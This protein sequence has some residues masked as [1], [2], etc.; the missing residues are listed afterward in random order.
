MLQLLFER[1]TLFPKYEVDFFV[2]VYIISKSKYIAYIFDHV[3]L[4]DNKIIDTFIE[5]NVQYTHSHGSLFSN[6]SLYHTIISN[7]VYLVITRP[8]I[9]YDIHVVSEFFGSLMHSFFA[10]LGIYERTQF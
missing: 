3:C 9:A 8:N 7:L 10:F 6:R 2:K 5:T 4:Y 1:I